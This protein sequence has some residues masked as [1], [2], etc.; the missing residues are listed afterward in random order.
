MDAQLQR[1][2]AQLERL[3]QRSLA[4]DESGAKPKKRGE[5]AAEGEDDSDLVDPS[6]LVGSEED[7]PEARAAFHAQQV[8]EDIETART[9][10]FDDEA[11]ARGGALAPGRVIDV[12]RDGAELSP[13]DRAV[14][15]SELAIDLPN[16]MSDFAALREAGFVDDG[17]PLPLTQGLPDPEP[18]PPTA[19]KEEQDTHEGVLRAARAHRAAA[20]WI[21]GITDLASLLELQDQYPPP[22][23]EEVHERQKLEEVDAEER[24]M[25]L[26]LRERYAAL[27]THTSWLITRLDLLLDSPASWEAPD[28]LRYRFIGEQLQ[29]AQQSALQSMAFFAKHAAALA[30]MGPDV[31]DAMARQCW[32]Q[33][34]YVTARQSH[35]T[36]EALAVLEHLEQW[37]RDDREAGIVRAGG[38]GQDIEVQRELAALHAFCSRWGAAIRAEHT[39]LQDCAS[40]SELYVEALREGHGAE[41][42][43]Y[44]LQNY[45]SDALPSLT[46]ISHA[47]LQFPN[48]EDAALQ[49]QLAENP[50]QPPTAEDGSPLPAPHFRD[51]LASVHVAQL[52]VGMVW[53]LASTLSRDSVYL[54]THLAEA[55]ARQQEQEE[56]AD[57][58][59]LRLAEHGAKQVE[60]LVSQ[61]A[62]WPTAED[63][64]PSNLLETALMQSSR[65]PRLRKGLDTFLHFLDRVPFGDA[66]A[67]T[68]HAWSL[69]ALTTRLEAAAAHQQLG[70]AL[71]AWLEEEEE[72]V[73]RRKEAREQG[74]AEALKQAEE[75]LSLSHG[76]QAQ[77]RQ[78]MITAFE[79]ARR[80]AQLVPNAVAAQ[81]VQVELDG[82]P[83]AEI[84]EL[85][86]KCSKGD[87]LPKL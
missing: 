58:L 1:A 45:S 81:R 6:T 85:V 27:V 52:A 73:Q 12:N 11:W 59:A 47:L 51:V 31:H 26:A 70:F 60:R 87:E 82:V 75:L 84:D 18:L 80:L 41:V 40:R 53:R 2:L 64:N 30:G 74:D 66:N 3:A 24:A 77:L 16:H 38:E 63:L 44:G 67:P 35:L 32:S 57:R 29:R 37:E 86:N 69:T 4:E 17:T 55:Q 83:Q 34:A 61:H 65:S 7:T 54:R 14:V 5:D 36:E 28:K 13:R 46:R 50:D 68:R 43:E 62:S 48:E 8:D 22:T 9:R 76:D 33:L 10:H 56:I 42:P 71:K 72:L 23:A 21:D 20:E 78:C 25:G 79:T 19:S 15:L 39:F 49:Q